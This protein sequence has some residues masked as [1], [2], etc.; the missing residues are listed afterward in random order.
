MISKDE[1]SKFI[2]KVL[3]PGS[4]VIEI[5][6]LGKGMH[7]TGFLIRTKTDGDNEERYVLKTIMEGGFGHEYPSDRAKFVVD[8]I[9]N[10][11]ELPKGNKLMAAGSVQE[12]GSLVDLKQ[13]KDFFMIVEEFQGREYWEYLQEARDTGKLDEKGREALIKLADYLAD[14]HAIKPQEQAIPERY[15]KF[16][17]D[18]V[19]A[20]ELTMGVLDTFPEEVPFASKQDF[21]EI[22]QKQIEWWYKIKNKHHRLKTVHGDF[23]PANIIFTDSD[24]EVTDRARTRYGDVCHDVFDI[25]INILYY[26]ILTYGDIRDPFKEMFEVFMERYL[27]KTGDY[28]MFEVAP[29][30]ISFILIV[31][32]HPLFYSSE[33]M[34]KQKFSDDSINKIDERKKLLVTFCKNLLNDSKFDYKNVSKYFE[35]PTE[36]SDNYVLW[37]TGL[38]GSGKSTHAKNAVKML[39]K[40]G[41]DI[42]YLR[43]D[44]LVKELKMKRKYDEEERDMFYRYAVGLAKRLSKRSHV[45]LDAVGHRKEWRDLARELIPNFVEVYVTCPLDLAIKRETERK[46]NLIVQDMYKKAQERLKTGKTIVGLGEV[47]GVDVPYEEPDNPE[48]IIASDKPASYIKIVSKQLFDY[49]HPILNPA[50]VD[51]RIPKVIDILKRITDA[52]SHGYPH[53]IKVMNRCFFLGIKEDANLKVLGPAALLHDIGLYMGGKG[54]QHSRISAEKAPKYLTEAGYSKNEQKPIIHAIVMH[55]CRYEGGEPGTTEAKV[56]IDADTIEKIGP[57]SISRANKCIKERG[58]TL[59]EWSKQWVETRER[60]I[61]ENKLFYTQSG[62][63][64]GEKPLQET[65]KYWRSKK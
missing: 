35:E 11:P 15:K 60:L 64:C 5:K 29:H 14:F 43:M 8:S 21:I 17:R 22:V 58:E 44:K 40:E 31:A 26:S 23:Y 19:G 20:G 36:T 61:K 7:G 63:S 65:L 4:E 39:H 28:E 33:W 25:G 30:F 49:V 27:E 1:L 57:A 51:E 54:K 56:L 45:L 47:I 41:V 34:K 50:S 6:E 3:K 9:I 62:K 2:S 55:N 59:K 42:E 24:F 18:F 12:D 16:V 46:N 10:Y 38:P 52:G 48:I 53:A 37:V 32:M 13:P